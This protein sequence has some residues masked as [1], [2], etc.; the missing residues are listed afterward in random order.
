VEHDSEG[1]ILVSSGIFER[2]YQSTVSAVAKNEEDGF[3]LRSQ[4]LSV[5]TLLPAGLPKPTGDRA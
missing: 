1:K 5:T 2:H 3:I 4:D